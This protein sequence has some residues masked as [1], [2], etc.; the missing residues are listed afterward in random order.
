MS[1][2]QRYYHIWY[3]CYSYWKTYQSGMTWG[4]ISL[5]SQYQH[6]MGPEAVPGT[7]LPCIP[8]PIGTRFYLPDARHKWAWD[9]I[10]VPDLYE[11]FKLVPNTSKYLP[12]MKRKKTLYQDQSGN[13]CSKVD[14]SPTLKYTMN[15]V[16][17]YPGLNFT[18]HPLEHHERW[19]VSGEEKKI[20]WVPD[21][22]S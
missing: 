2:L 4:N 17:S 12:G 22:S 21:F 14:N 20:C 7:E 9:L 5:I 3:W 13:I 1:E 8:V 19:M 16:F 10:W 11:S 6:G 18:L 15:A